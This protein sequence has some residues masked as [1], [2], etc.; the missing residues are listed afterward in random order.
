M[1]HLALL[2]DSPDEGW[3]SMDLVA[4][5]LH[6]E[7]KRHH[8]HQL[9]V[10]RVAPRFRRILSRANNRT[11]KGFKVDR[12]VHRF[13][14]YPRSLKPLTSNFDLYHIVDHSY[15]QLVHELP[16]ERAVVTCHDL[17][18]FRCILEPP[19][20]RRSP[21]FKL[22]TRRI[23]SGFM[24]AA[25]VLCVS[26][27]VRRDLINSGLVT[28]DRATTVPNGVHPAYSPLPND[29]ADSQLEKL[30]PRD[31]KTPFLLHV[32]STIP[33]KRIDTLLRAFAAVRTE[34]PSAI[35]IRVGG[36]L[37]SSQELLARELGI[38]N[39]IIRLPFLETQT[40]A[41]V[42]RRAA[43]LLLTSEAEGFGLPLV[44]AM[45]CGCP[46][47]ASD[48]PVMREVGGT[49]V[50]FC[51]VGCHIRWAETIVCL[52]RNRQKD[53]NRW[54][55]LRVACQERASHYTWH[56]TATQCLRI[57]EKILDRRL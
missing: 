35:L 2:S 9:C 54:E 22:M 37:T 53:A 48:I 42:Y 32:G 47:V 30:L 45:A 51:P 7:L 29:L 57:Y 55:K 23:A 28:A 19:R 13:W 39:S 34:L 5:S 6:D 36:T 3:I 18:T 49:A 41:A 44:E 15:A 26:D 25:H 16:A 12:I 46:V 21:P 4:D 27:A 1:P 24:K 11:G 50:I 52:L 56:H 43:I 14:D 8:S 31:E 17:D 33:R 40:L 38:E 20:E 10:T